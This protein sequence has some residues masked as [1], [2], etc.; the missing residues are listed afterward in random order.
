MRKELDTRH[1][2]GVVLAKTPLWL[3]IGVFIGFLIQA[4]TA[5]TLPP[6]PVFKAG[7]PLSSQVLTEAFAAL[8]G[9]FEQRVSALEATVVPPG[10]VVAYA[11]AIAPPGWLLCDG[12]SHDKSELPALWNA[13]QFSHGG[14]CVSKFNLPDYRGRFL[15]GVDS[16]SANRDPDHD[17]RQAP[18][19][20][21]A[22]PG[23]DKNKVGSVQGDN[24]LG[25]SHSASGNLSVK[26]SNGTGPVGAGMAAGNGGGDYFDHGVSV[27]VNPSGGS[28]T[29]PRNAYVHWIIKY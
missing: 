8:H 12:S 29:R 25:H 7:E 4:T 9:E 18:Q 26:E 15:R 19:L 24:Y 6:P 3:G 22:C 23:D 27:S 2:L 17:K 20:T 14:D 11:S 13:I 28:E 21:Q 5:S 10:T 16:G 1:G